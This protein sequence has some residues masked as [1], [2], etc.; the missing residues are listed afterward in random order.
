MSQPNTDHLRALQAEHD[1]C[2]AIDSD[3][4]SGVYSWN[5]AASTHAW[6]GAQEAD[7][8]VRFSTDPGVWTGLFL[9][10]YEQLVWAHVLYAYRQD[11]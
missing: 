8:V 5:Y 10:D 3:G 9:Y 11:W 4:W 7:Y 6:S 1:F 2:I